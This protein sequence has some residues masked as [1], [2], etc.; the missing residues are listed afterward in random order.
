[1]KINIKYKIK[2][3]L[4]LVITG[5]IRVADYTKQ[6]RVEIINNAPYLFPYI[7]NPDYEDK[8]KAVSRCPSNI[9]FIVY[10]SYEMLEKIIYFGSNLSILSLL[11]KEVSEDVLSRL[12]EIYPNGFQYIKHQTF[13]IASIAIIKNLNNYQYLDKDCYTKKELNKLGALYRRQERIRLEQE[14]KAYERVYN[15]YI[16]SQEQLSLLPFDNDSK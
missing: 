4:R 10:P 7:S 1:M 3:E 15:T 2:Q 6:Q 8:M 16:S 5:G 13:K 14:R 12:L 9:A 11:T